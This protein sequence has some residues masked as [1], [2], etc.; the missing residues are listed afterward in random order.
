MPDDA[1]LG[2]Y[3]GEACGFPGHMCNGTGQCV[4]FGV[5]LNCNDETK[6]VSGNALYS[7]YKLPWSADI[8]QSR[9]IFH[10]IG[11]F[12]VFTEEPCNDDFPEC[13]RRCTKI[14]MAFSKEICKEWCCKGGP[15]TVK[16]GKNKHD[17]T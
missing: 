6:S 9:L 4:F 10:L 12:F 16:E 2:K 13:M 17:S 15:R 1:C 3:C 8:T 11:G 7:M 5:P 14:A